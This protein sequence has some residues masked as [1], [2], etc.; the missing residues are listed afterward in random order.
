M[1]IQDDR[2]IEKQLKQDPGSRGVLIVLVIWNLAYDHRL[3]G[4]S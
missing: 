2:M 3:R 4:K 1:P